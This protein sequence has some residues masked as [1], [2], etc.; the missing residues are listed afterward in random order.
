V[1]RTKRR[2]Y[3]RN[4]AIAL[5]NRGKEDALPTLAEA[6]QDSEPLIRS[7][8]AWALG[9]IGGNKSKSILNDAA[10]NEEH[11]AVIQDITNAL[12]AI[13]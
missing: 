7:H 8:A 3:L 5:G 1:K 13:Q 2:G 12:K 9:T 4:V 11:P 6:L 10:S